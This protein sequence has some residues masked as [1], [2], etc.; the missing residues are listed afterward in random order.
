MV[1]Y[2]RGYK[3]PL[4]LGYRGYKGPFQLGNMYAHHFLY[5]PNKIASWVKFYVLRIFLM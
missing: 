3:R 1:L 5:Y 2:Y 4:E